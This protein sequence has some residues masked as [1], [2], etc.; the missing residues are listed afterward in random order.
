M[1]G[2][3]EDPWRLWSRC[4]QLATLPG[5]LVLDPTGTKHTLAISRP[6]PTRR[7]YHLPARSSHSNSECTLLFKSPYQH[8]VVRSAQSD[9]G[10]I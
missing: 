2:P 8:P 10:G 7:V 3:S 4:L 5:I 9:G 1:P 6:V